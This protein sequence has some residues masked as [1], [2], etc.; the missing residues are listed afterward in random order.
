MA[1]FVLSKLCNGCQRCEKACPY[2]AIRME[3][4]LAVVEEVECKECEECLE[5]CMMGAITFVVQKISES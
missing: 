4:S 1:A 5:V 3:M 2:G